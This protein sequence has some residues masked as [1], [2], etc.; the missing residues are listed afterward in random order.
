MVL[1]ISPTIIIMSPMVLIIPYGSQD[2][3]HMHHDIPQGKYTA[4]VL[5]TPHD[6][7]HMLHRVLYLAIKRRPQ[8]EPKDKIKVNKL[9]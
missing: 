2:I 8:S 3:P 1:K 7:A 9:N 4:T 6:N 5:H